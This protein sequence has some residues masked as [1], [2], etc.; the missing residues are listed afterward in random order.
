MHALTLIQGIGSSGLF[1]S[2]AFLPALLTAI[3][4]RFGPEW[5][6]LENTGIFNWIEGTPTW[7]THDITVIVLSFLSLVEFFAYKSPD[8]RLFLSEIDTYLKAG[9]SGL[10]QLGIISA[11]DMEFVHEGI[12]SAGF[13][14]YF[15]T[16]AVVSGVFFLSSVRNTLLRPLAEA[17][18][19]D[20]LQIQSLIS[21][22]EDLWVFIGF[23]LLVVAPLFMIF[24]IA[25]I[26]GLLVAAKKYLEKKE[27][28]IKIACVNCNTSIFPCAIA[29][30][31][32][33]TE[34]PAPQDIGFL[35][36]AINRPARHRKNHAI[37]LAS[38]KRCSLCASRLKE[39][40]PIQ[41]CIACGTNSMEEQRFSQAYIKNV[42][43]KLLPV[44]LIVFAL[45]M[46]PVLGMIVSFI[47]YRSLLV[48][49]FRRY[50][51]KHRRFGIKWMMRLV[52]YCAFVLQI[53]LGGFVV[54]ALALLEYFTYR[55]AYETE[56]DKAKNTSASESR[57]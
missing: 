20:D 33:R 47:Y 12:Q 46:V 40:N 51:P 15:I 10:T 35:G 6:W 23:F 9:S 5:E 16:I 7:F 50:I 36:Q 44:I 14:D 48:A 29:C 2:R 21:W 39:S 38:Y 1:A 3:V 26:S 13:G 52:R 41:R 42:E 55:K 53:F 17:D 56:L 11:A 25:C 49:P 24:C 54:S 43:S 4:L 34:N 37:K 19:D 57:H 22:T 30:P 28:A 27:A 45:G 18:E 31:T 32:C 8:A